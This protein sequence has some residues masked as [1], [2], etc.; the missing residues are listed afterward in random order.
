M[1]IT[2]LETFTTRDVGF[3]RATAE[4]ERESVRARLLELL[5]VLS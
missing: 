2:K 5:V 1:K 3:V 4:E